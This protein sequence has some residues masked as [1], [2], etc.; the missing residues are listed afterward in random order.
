MSVISKMQK[1]LN[2]LEA[3]LEKLEE[4][5]TGGRKQQEVADWIMSKFDSKR[6]EITVRRLFDLG[7]KEKGYR[8]QTLQLARRHLLDDKIGIEH[9][10][11]KGWMWVKVDDL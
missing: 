4:K 1:R 5:G 9:R 2:D 8:Y 11:G 6:N 7:K 10:K 3:R